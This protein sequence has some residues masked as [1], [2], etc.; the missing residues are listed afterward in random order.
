MEERAVHSNCKVHIDSSFPPL[1]CSFRIF[2]ILISSYTIRQILLQIRIANQ[3][4]QKYFISESRS[5][6]RVIVDRQRDRVKVCA[7]I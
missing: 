2:N 1:L 3:N 6:I 5:L 7:R 4:T